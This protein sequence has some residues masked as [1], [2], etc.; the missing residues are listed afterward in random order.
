MSS[1]VACYRGSYKK[2]GLPI[3]ALELGKIHTSDS[4]V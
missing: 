1:F 2:S 3:W 4:E